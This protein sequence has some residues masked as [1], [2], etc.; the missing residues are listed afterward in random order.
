[1]TASEKVR[2]ELDILGLDASA[3]ILA[4][5]E[6]FFAAAGITRARDLLRCRSRAEVLVAGVKVAT[7]TPPI[8]SGR[9]VVFVTLDDATGP[10]DATFFEEAQAGYAATVFHSWLLVIRGTVRRTGPR[11]ISLQA[12]GCWELPLLR[13]LWETDGLTAVAE[14]L[15]APPPGFSE[16]ATEGAAESRSTRPV[17]APVRRFASGF[18]LSAYSDIKPAGGD[19]GRPRAGCGTPAPAA[20]VGRARLGARLRYPARRWLL[21]RQPGLW[22]T[23]L[24]PPDVP[25]PKAESRSVVVATRRSR[26]TTRNAAV[27]STLRAALADGQSAGRRRSTRADLLDIL[28]AGGGTGGF[29]VPL[30]ELGHRVTVVDPSPDSLAALERRAAEAGIHTIRGVQGDAAGLLDVAAARVLRRRAVPP[31]A[32]SGRRPGSRGRGDGTGAA[33]RRSAQRAGRQR[34]RRGAQPGGRRSARRGD[35]VARG[36]PGLVGPARPA[37]PALR[38]GEHPRPARRRRARGHRAAR[39]PGVQRPAARDPCSTSTRPRPRRSLRLE[40]LVVDRPEFTDVAAA[41]HVLARRPGHVT[42]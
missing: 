31:R 40:E 34:Q 4:F 10:V 35:R 7:Q 29:A 1:M 32:R 5:Y 39:L 20:P 9:R 36:R 17:M 12:D 3:H 2:A 37:G 16:L 22:V 13:E 42:G 30:A 8:R 26:A 18:E 33:P 41:L 15:A 19:S 25:R 28:D 24:A 27:W 11:G 38:P 6:Q 14:A 23:R 21:S